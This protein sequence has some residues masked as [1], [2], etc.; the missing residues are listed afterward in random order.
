M[1]LYTPLKVAEIL[2][3]SIKQVDKLYNQR[4]LKRSDRNRGE[5]VRYTENSVL[6]FL[7][8]RGYVFEEIHFGEGQVD[9]VIPEQGFLKTGN[10]SKVTRLSPNTVIA[11]LEK[12][13]FNGYSLPGKGTTH[14]RICRDSLKRVLN[15]SGILEFT[16]P[17]T[18]G[19]CGLLLP[20][21]VQGKAAA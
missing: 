2:G 13:V 1:K 9:V 15:E 20:S 6:E 17:E 4:Y 19:E 21:D 14:H 8:E 3:I 7:A 16:S 10:V 5:P 11:R 18:L 12:G